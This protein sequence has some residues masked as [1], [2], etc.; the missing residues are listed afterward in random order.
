MFDKRLSHCPCGGTI[1][2]S[3]YTVGS[4]NY[5]ITK[6]GKLSKRYTVSKS[7]GIDSATASCEKCG[8]YWDANSF[9]IHND[10]FWT[11]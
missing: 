1:V 11:D 3:F 10:E 5:R 4:Q 6:K 2:V 8:K 7:E 9:I